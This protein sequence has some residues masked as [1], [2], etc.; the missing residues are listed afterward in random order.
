[1]GLSECKRNQSELY[2]KQLT[3]QAENFLSFTDFFPV[4]F[5]TILVFPFPVL[6]AI[7]LC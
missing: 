4:L 2:G 1:M 6:F 7:E 3:D 5:C